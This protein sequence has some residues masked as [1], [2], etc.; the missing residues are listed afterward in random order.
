MSHFTRLK[1]RMI[2]KEY[3][4]Q[5]LKD[6]GY[7]YEE[8]EVTVRG[9]AGAQEKA[10]L[11]IRAADHQEREIG[12]AKVDDAY[13]IVADWWG[14]GRQ[15]EEF[16]QQVTRRY[17]YHAARTKLEAQRFNLVDEEVG[18]DGTVRLVLRRMG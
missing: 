12:F 13:E 2:E 11:K 18:Q 17:A 9:F 7:T 3:L 14:L 15:R 4:L 16:E 1:T 10:D 5:A 6:L 8:G